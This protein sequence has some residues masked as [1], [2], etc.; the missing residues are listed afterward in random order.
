MF[1]TVLCCHLLDDRKHQPKVTKK[2]PKKVRIR[3]HTS[4][5]RNK[6]SSHYWIK[7]GSS[8]TVLI[9]WIWKWEICPPPPPPFRSTTWWFCLQTGPMWRT[10][11]ECKNMRTSSRRRSR[12]FTTSTP[13]APRSVSTRTR[14]GPGFVPASP[15]PAPPLPTLSPLSLSRPLPSEADGASGPCHLWCHWCVIRQCGLE[16]T[17]HK[18]LQSQTAILNFWK[19]KS[20]V[21][22]L[23]DCVPQ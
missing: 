4:K 1:K 22:S 14:K 2:E 15:A 20:P 3:L 6:I 23:K 17:P 21:T 7:G 9:K 10:P 16:G 11:A 5:N 13:L 19:K 8:V 12:S 18:P